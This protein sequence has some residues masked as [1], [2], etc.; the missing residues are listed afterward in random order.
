MQR[1]KILPTVV[2]TDGNHL[3]KLKEVNQLGLAEVCFFP[4]CLNLEE[5]KNFYLLLEKSCLKK[6]PLVHLKDDF[7]LWEIEYFLKR[8]RTEVFNTHT[9]LQYPIPQEWLKCKDKIYIENTI[10][11]WEAKELKKFGGICLDFSHLE[12]ARLLRREIYEANIK[13]LDEHSCGCAHISAVKKDLK[14]NEEWDLDYYGDHY[15][16]TLS[17][18]DYLKNYPEKYF[19]EIIAIEL[20]NPIKEQLKVKE[21]LE[22][23]L[24]F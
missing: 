23:M 16:E 5:R 8:F 22:K 17:E 4:T 13:L 1:R 9:S 24:N 15:F 21:Y 7:K 19:P 12:D 3:K 18:F 6:I 10:F 2:T 11:P 14:H 20:E